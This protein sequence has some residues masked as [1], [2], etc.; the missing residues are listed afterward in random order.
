MDECGL[1]NVHTPQKIIATK[2]ARSV[3][4][5]TS[6][7]RGTLFTTV[8]AYSAAGC[9]LPPMLIFPRQRMT[10][11]FMK[12]APIQSIGYASPEGWTDTN[13]F[14]KWLGHLVAHVQPS[15]QDQ[16]IILFDGHHAHKTLKAITYARAHGINMITLPP[17]T[18]HKLQPL[19]RTFFKSLRSAYNRGCD[20]WMSAN[21]GRHIQARCCGNIWQCSREG[22]YTGQINFW[23]PSYW[24]VSSQP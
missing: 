2:G 3:G 4:K 1:T 15:Q 11:T 17:H 14:L 5:V 16:H 10:D 22:S 9:Y 20:S 8:C 7:E 6:G 21:A 23:I 19:D 18:T 12:G 13:L 24:L